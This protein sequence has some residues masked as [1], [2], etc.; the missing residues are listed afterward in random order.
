MLHAWDSLL[1]KNA[2]ISQRGRRAPAKAQ[3]R[4]DQEPVE[5][6]ISARVPRTSSSAKGARS[7][8]KAYTLGF[9]GKV[10]RSRQSRANCSILL[11]LLQ[12]GCATKRQFRHQRERHARIRRVRCQG[13]S[14]ARSLPTGRWVSATQSSYKG[15]PLSFPDILSITSEASCTWERYSNCT[16]R[17][18]QRR[19]VADRAEIIDKGFIQRRAKIPAWRTPVSLR[20]SSG[21]PARQ[22]ITRRRKRFRCHSSNW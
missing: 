6:R 13:T 15:L 17:S 5:T 7:S 1:C 10:P 22:L 21:I 20:I 8:V 18:G 16:E 3:L 12:P 11:R 4:V 19:W 9:P 2:G 14:L